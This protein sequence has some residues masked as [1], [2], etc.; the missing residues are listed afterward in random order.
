MDPISLL[1]PLLSGAAGGNIIGGVLKNFN[2]GSAGNTLAGLV[3]GGLGSTILSSLMGA[4]GAAA[5]LDGDTNALIS[6][7]LGGGVGGGAITM[8]IAM[9]QGLFQKR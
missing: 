5:G 4:G 3:G 2:L 9:L 8:L 1:L 7:I 6:Q